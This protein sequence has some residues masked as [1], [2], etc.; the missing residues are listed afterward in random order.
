MQREVRN[1]VFG[2]VCA[3]GSGG[4]GREEGRGEG[5]VFVSNC[6]LAI[7]LV[8]AGLFFM[9]N[10]SIFCWFGSAFGGYCTN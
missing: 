1:L 2:Y 7:L 10:E 8:Y 3:A 5:N 6:Q 4:W 9:S